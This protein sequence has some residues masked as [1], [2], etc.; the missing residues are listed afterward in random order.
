MFG[1][2]IDG[3]TA[4]GLAVVAALL[5]GPVFAE[6]AGDRQTGDQPTDDTLIDNGPIDNTPINNRPTDSGPID[7]PINGPI[8]GQPTDDKRDILVTFV[9][10]GARRTAVAADSRTGIE[11]G[12]R[13]R[14][15]CGA[16]P[17]ALRPTTR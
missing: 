16:T 13:F 2:Q 15:R 14:P 12:I 11:N 17:A 3:R 10:D 1:G 5:I 4:A 8:D 6:S 9:N 7:G